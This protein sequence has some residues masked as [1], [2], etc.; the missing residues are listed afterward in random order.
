[1]DVT[2]ELKALLSRKGISQ[3]ELAN[4]AKV[5]QSTVSRAMRSEPS[6]KSK[7]YARLC[8]Y[9]H[10]E[11]DE[12][13]LPAAVRDALAEIW[14]GSPAQAE[15]LATLI[16]AAGDLSRNSGTEDGSS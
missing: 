15:A 12:I 6:R 3:S 5:S 7:S 1:M 14:D 8:S 9:I 2:S 13:S 11:T 10:K 16:R 4:R